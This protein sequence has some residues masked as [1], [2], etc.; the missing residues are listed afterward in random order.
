MSSVKATL[1]GLLAIVLWSSTVG[2][3]RIVSSSFGTVLAAFLMHAIGAVVLFFLLGLTKPTHLKRNYLIFG[4]LTF[5]AYLFCVFFAVGMAQNSQQAIEVG[6]VNYLW[7][8]LVI[9]SAVI[10][11][12][13]YAN[14]YLLLPGF[15]IAITGISLVLGGHNGLN[16]VSIINNIK[17]NPLSYL[18]AFI[19]ANIWAIYCTI[20]V[21]TA[22]GQNPITLFFIFTAGA[23]GILYLAMGFEPITI[24][25]KAIIYLLLATLANCFGYAAWNIGILH[26]NVSLLAGI[27]YFIPVLSAII[28]AIMLQTILPIQFWYGA[29]M[30]C[31]G[32]VLCWFATRKK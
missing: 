15:L 29:A 23:F 9:I 12:K 25:F 8:A 1:I 26:G 18:L 31:V 13:Q 27:S 30:V 11:N 24:N 20:T 14:W 19:G 2:F 17:L 5:V 32:S 22:Q 21:R 10:F 7:P 6:M 4:S 3:I 28:S 16:L